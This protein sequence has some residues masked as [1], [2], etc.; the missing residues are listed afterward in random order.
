M[1]RDSRD[2]IRRLEREGFVLVSVSGS[3]HKFVHA[4][5]HRRVIVPHP[6]CDLPIGTVRAIYRD[7]GWQKD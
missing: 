6:K 3:H 7:A 1:L 4:T 5:Q 2:I